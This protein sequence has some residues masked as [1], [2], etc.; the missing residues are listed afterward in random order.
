M[1]NWYKS[2]RSAR[3]YNVV[4]SSAQ[5]PRV[6]CDPRRAGGPTTSDLFNVITSHGL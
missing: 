1:S 3:Y 2:Q 4:I 5:Y 6:A